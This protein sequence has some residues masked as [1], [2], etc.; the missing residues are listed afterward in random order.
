MARYDPLKKRFTLVMGKGGVGKS[1]ITAALA[2]SAA[3]KGKKVLVAEVNANERMSYFFGSTS[4]GSEIKE[5]F[6]NIFAVNMNPSDTI[7]ELVI[8]HL[9][10]RLIYEAVFENR[11]IKYFLQAIPAL[12]ELV[13]QGKLKHHEQEQDEETGSPRFDRIIVDCPSTGHGISFLAV[14]SELCKAVPGGQF[15]KH[16]QHVRDLLTDHETT[17]LH[18]VTHLEEM[19]VNEAKEIFQS[20]RDYLNISVGGLFIN[21][22]LQPTFFSD[23]EM[24]QVNELEKIHSSEKYR[25]IPSLETLFKTA[26][27]YQS[28]TQLERHYLGQLKEQMDLPFFQIPYL[29]TDK[30]NFETIRTISHTIENNIQ[31]L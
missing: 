8:Y 4:V 20:A 26:S 25:E 12:G 18:I 3:M 5:I 2:Y 23:Q 19:P 15:F 13:M 24:K 9:K 17:Q 29:F 21:N 1:T 31:L 28:R 6:P 11:L 16:A 30:F 10:Y 14:S 7:R 27:I 22:I